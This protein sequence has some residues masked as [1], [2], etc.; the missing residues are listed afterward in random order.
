LLVVG[1]A[2]KTATDF[3]G[4]TR[5]QKRSKVWVRESPG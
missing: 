5:I 3:P 4:F 2:K 1:K